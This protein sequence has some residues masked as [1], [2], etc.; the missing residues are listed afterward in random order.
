MQCRAETVNKRKKKTP[1]DITKSCN[2]YSQCKNSR[3]KGRKKKQRKPC[4]AF[5]PQFAKRTS[6]FINNH[7][8][9][10]YKTT[11]KALVS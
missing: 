9:Q 4:S 1:K 3:E 5:K 6:V 7:N 2:G 11:K 8:N 10:I